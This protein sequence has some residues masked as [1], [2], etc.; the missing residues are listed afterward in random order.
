MGGRGRLFAVTVR[1]LMLDC[2]LSMTSSVNIVT[3][4]S[5]GTA[6]DADANNNIWLCE[7]CC[8][9]LGDFHVKFEHVADCHGFKQLNNEMCLQAR[10]MFICTRFSRASKY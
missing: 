2:F 5:T 1:R 9:D 4:K 10:L 7:F 6:A 8:V 3:I